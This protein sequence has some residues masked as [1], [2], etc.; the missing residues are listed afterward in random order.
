MKEK[1]ITAVS[2]IL[3][4]IPWSILVLRTNEW[5]L[6]KPAAGIIILSYAAFMIAQAAFVLWGYMKGRV[7]NNLMKLCLVINC[8]YGV[9]GIAVIVMILVQKW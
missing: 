1:I 7:Q 3:L 9:G 4:F 5:A 8:L 6:E 2:A